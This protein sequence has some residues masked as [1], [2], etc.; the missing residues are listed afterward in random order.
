[1]FRKHSSAAAFEGNHSE[2]PKRHTCK[3]EFSEFTGILAVNAP[4]LR[5]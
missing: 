3:A 5:L 1:M 4:L 2:I